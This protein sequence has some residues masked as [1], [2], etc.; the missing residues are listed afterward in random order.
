MKWK[1]AWSYLASLH[2]Q[3][4]LKRKAVSTEPMNRCTC[5][6]TEADKMDEISFFSRSDRGKKWN[7][8]S[9]VLARGGLT[10]HV[11]FS[12]KNSSYVTEVCLRLLVMQSWIPISKLWS[13]LN[14]PTC[15]DNLCYCSWNLY[16]ICMRYVIYIS[17]RSAII[18]YVMISRIRRIFPATTYVVVAAAA[19]SCAV[20]SPRIQAFLLCSLAYQKSNS[21]SLS[22]GELP[23]SHPER[24]D[25]VKIPHTIDGLNLRTSVHS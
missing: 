12:C 10:H 15:R 23:S 16:V 6:H 1:L 17:L 8:S 7:F 9:F 14:W 13:Q 19:F 22:T 24:K 5:D 21:C 20:H 25:N 18:E 11:H 2:C 4:R 3:N